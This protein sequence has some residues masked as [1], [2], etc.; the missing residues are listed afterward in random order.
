MKAVRT[1]LIVLFC[2]V[3]LLALILP[4]MTDK[5]DLIYTNLALERLEAFRLEAL[6]GDISQAAYNLKEVV[7]DSPTKVPHDG[8]SSRTYE[9]ARAAAIREI[10]SRMR[11]LSGEDLGED[12]KLWIEKYSRKEPAQADKALQ[13]TSTPSGST[14][15]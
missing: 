9:L 2:V 1:T 11:S 10:I 5:N 8:D 15:R 7:E 13:P 3:P 14:N 6:G 4:K 12:P